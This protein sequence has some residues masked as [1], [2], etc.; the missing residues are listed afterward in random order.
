MARNEFDRDLAAVRKLRNQAATNGNVL[1]SGEMPV[2]G[3]SV[4]PLKQP[5][6][7]S[8]AGP[9]SASDLPP[10]LTLNRVISDYLRAMGKFILDLIHRKFG[11]QLLMCSG[12]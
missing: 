7:G 12:V 10:G 11:S 2:V 4:T 9:S 5:I 8:D 6:S 1:S 3:S